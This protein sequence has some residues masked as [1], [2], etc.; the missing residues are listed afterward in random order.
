MQKMKFKIG[1][2]NHRED[3][4]ARKTNERACS[5]VSRGGARLHMAE[6]ILGD[7]T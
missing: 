1:R 7:F 5:S 3:T 4:A 6:A 2:K